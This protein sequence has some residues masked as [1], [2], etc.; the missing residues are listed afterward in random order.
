[1][2][3]FQELKHLL[4]LLYIVPSLILYIII[5]YLI[6]FSS[7]KQKF[8]ASFY[9]IFGF[10]AINYILHAVVYYFLI[11]FT[12]IPAFFTFLQNSP[13]ENFFYPIFYALLYYSG[14]GIHLYSLMISFNRFTIFILKTRYDTFWR[15]YLKYILYLCVFG[16]LIF[17]WNFPFMNIKNVEI[18]GYGAYIYSNNRI[19]IMVEK[20]SESCF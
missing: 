10:S 9:W 17:I 3:T 6:F 19:S 14:H 18:V 11:R 15:N 2:T 20:I 16:P 7:S 5:L 8:S 4:S 12:A 1:M 13:K